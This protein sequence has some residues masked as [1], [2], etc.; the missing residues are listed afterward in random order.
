MT[1]LVVCAGLAGVDARADTAA[2]PPLYPH[3][4]DDPV[5]ANTATQSFAPPTVTNVSIN[6]YSTEIVGM[7]AGGST[8]TT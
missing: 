5:Y 1:S 7:L 6:A 2:S 4:G 3:P 8:I